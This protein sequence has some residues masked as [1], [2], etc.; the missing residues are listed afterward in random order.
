M[1]SRTRIS[2]DDPVFQGRLR[3]SRPPLDY[4]N[5]T[6][7]LNRGKFRD[8]YNPVRNKPLATQHNKKVVSHNKQK[9]SPKLQAAN[10]TR[11]PAPNPY[12]DRQMPSNVLWRQ[13]NSA[14]KSITKSKKHRFSSPTLL[15]GLAVLLFT[16]GLVVVFNSL[17][18]DHTVKA[19]VK[20]IAKQTEDGT[21][22]T[23]LP[24]EENP[25]SNIGSYSVAPDL[26]KLLTIE[27]I[28]VNARVKRLGVDQNNVLK[29]P[30]NIYDI[31]WYE[32]SS[33]PGEGGTI[34]MDGHVSGPTKHGVF[35]G[36]N[37]LSAGDKIA[38]ER[39]DGTKFNY[40][41][42]ATETYAADNVDMA[43]VMTSPVLGK[44]ALNL[45]TCAGQ[46]DS[47]TNK[48]EQRV[49]VFTVQD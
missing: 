14:P 3:S 4:V 12:M 13:A 7:A 37:K 10:V 31:G 48:Y 33:K 41:V 36:L 22:A 30:A 25:P 1:E 17:R 29:A 34:V 49:V 18:T 32:G 28:G 9:P 21:I 46:F 38:L 19:Q 43:K 15:T 2:L 27:K 11:T 23:G 8:F 42:T 35:Y 24:S 5:G 6:N 16:A 47:K 40:T 44:P 20:Q 39:G 45:I 26:P